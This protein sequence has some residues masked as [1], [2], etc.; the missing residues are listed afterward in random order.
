MHADGKCDSSP[1]SAGLT[2]DAALEGH[3]I[4]ATKMPWG[5]HEV[6]RESLIAR[7]RRN[8]S[9]VS[10][11]KTLAYPCRAHSWR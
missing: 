8:F 1:K 11:G 4:N 2:I 9:L 7:Q 5:T 3:L 10:M 6:P